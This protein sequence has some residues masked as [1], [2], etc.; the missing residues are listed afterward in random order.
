[1]VV[2]GETGFL[3]KQQD[4]AALAEAFAILARDVARRHTMGRAARAFAV[5]HFDS[6]RTAVRL[7][8]HIARFTPAI[9]VRE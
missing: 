2:D 6:R 3:C 7:W 9:G 8:E 1:M 4:V 5:E